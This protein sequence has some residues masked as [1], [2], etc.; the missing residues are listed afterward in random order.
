MDKTFTMRSVSLSNT[1]LA[2][3]PVPD[4]YADNFAD[5]VVVIRDQLNEIIELIPI[6]PRLHG[7]FALIRDQQYDEGEESETENDMN[8][9]GWLKM[10]RTRMTDAVVRFF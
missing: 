8:Q 4:E 2:V 3:T 7:L 9:V 10:F 1:I 5:D 6:V